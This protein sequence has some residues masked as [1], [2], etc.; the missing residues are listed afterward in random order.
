[1]E[2]RRFFLIAIFAALLFF[3]YQ[4]WQKDYPATTAPAVTAPAQSSS[5][6]AVGDD[7]LPAAPATA[8]AA[9]APDAAASA[10]APT[11]SA[12]IEVVTDTLR[13]QIALAGGDVRRV[14]LVGYPVSK[15]NPGTDLA[16]LDDRDPMFFILQSGLASAEKPLTSH[17]TVFA[18][19]AERFVLDSAAATLDVPLTTTDASGLVMTKVYR[20]TRGSYQIGLTQTVQNGTA[21]PLSASPYARLQR[22]P[23]IAGYEAPF[24]QTFI[25]EGF[26][27]QKEPG[28]YRF[29]KIA[30]DKLHK[31]PFEATQTGGWLAMLQHYFVAA[32]L[33]PAGEQATFAG[34]PSAVKGYLAQ[35]HGPLKAVAVASTLPRPSLAPVAP[36]SNSWRA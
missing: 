14:E 24:S 33:P 10:A 25:G 1:M 6:V 15:T 2:N 3:T 12:R 34:K 36:V 28:E 31:E 21:A 29:R 26:Y 11:T 17:N 5:P 18:T 22:T 32:I 23:H 7:A 8:A 35:Y 16:L 19:T 9:V 4:T 13:V 20:F 27:E 30:F